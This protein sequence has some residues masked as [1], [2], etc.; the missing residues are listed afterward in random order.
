[1]KSE[2]AVGP[3]KAAALRTRSRRAVA[4]RTR[5]EEPQPDGRRITKKGRGGRFGSFVARAPK[6]VEPLLFTG[7]QIPKKMPLPLFSTRLIPKAIEATSG[8]VHHKLKRLRMA[9]RLPAIPTTQQAFDVVHGYNGNWSS[10]I[11]NWSSHQP[12]PKI[13]QMKRSPVSSEPNALIQAQQAQAQKAIWSTPTKPLLK[14][15]PHGRLPA[16]ALTS[17]PS[18]AVSPSS[19]TQNVSSD[20]KATTSQ[21]VRTASIP[22]ARST[23]L[24]NFNS[25]ESCANED[26]VVYATHR[27]GRI[28]IQP[29]PSNSAKD[30][31]FY[32][33]QLHSLAPNE[34]Y[35]LAERDRQWLTKICPYQMS[36]KLPYCVRIHGEFEP[37]QQRIYEAAFAK[38]GTDG[39]WGYVACRDYLLSGKCTRG[40]KCT[41]RHF[42]KWI[43]L[44]DN[45]VVAILA[46]FFFNYMA[47][48]NAASELRHN[49]NPESESNHNNNNRSQLRPVHAP[50]YDPVLQRAR[51][52]RKHFD[53]SRSAISSERTPRLDRGL[54]FEHRLALEHMQPVQTLPPDHERKSTQFIASVP[55][56]SYNAIDSQPSGMQ[57]PSS[58]ENQAGQVR[59]TAEPGHPKHPR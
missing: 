19:Q 46:S 58:H 50:N 11:Y 4:L 2:P 38:H 28:Y 33:K 15:H 20:G 3:K 13:P 31:E 35:R 45:Q 27:I 40:L 32:W 55:E 5:S 34:V 25:A 7:L 29:P 48:A 51:M 26:D 47:I 23:N 1:M 44:N 8:C 18:Q 30:S 9:Y 6:I 21:D 56:N 57:P 41:F 14:P 59:P 12:P 42:L 39:G 36:C 54:V 37:N 24:H 49:A 22:D 10:S 53:P 52:G 16:L 43:P 17:S